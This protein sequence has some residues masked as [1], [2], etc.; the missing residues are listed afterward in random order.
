MRRAIHE[1]ELLPRE[2]ERHR[3]RAVLERHAPRLGG[4]VRV[5][6]TEHEEVRDAAQRREMLHRLVR[7]AVLAESDGVVREDIDALLPHQRGEADRRTHVVG[8][9]EEGAAVGDDP[10]VQ[11]HPVH[12]RAHRVLADAEVEVAAAALLRGEDLRS[13][14][15]R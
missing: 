6:G 4:L 12:H 11:R 2:H 3:P 8:E 5:A 15:C 1:R 7:G 9:D 13:P 14:W 10:A